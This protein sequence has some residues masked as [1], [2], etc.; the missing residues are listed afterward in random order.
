MANKFF[1]YS[2]QIRRTKTTGIIFIIFVVA[3]LVGAF[4]F[5]RSKNNITSVNKLSYKVVF[6]MNEF[7]DGSCDKAYR[8]SYKKNTCGTI[9]IK[10]LKK[11]KNFLDNTKNKMIENGFIINKIDNTEINNKKW[12]YFKTDNVPL[13]SYYSYD[14]LNKTY[15]IENIDQ[16]NYLT[17]SNKKECNNIYN[18]FKESWNIK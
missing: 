18:K 3:L 4:L 1:D 16:S 12:N 11:D 14:Y 15:V 13:V 17:K 7:E 9:C 2:F 6:G 8:I 5:Y 10:S